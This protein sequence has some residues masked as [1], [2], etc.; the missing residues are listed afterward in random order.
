MNGRAIRTKFAIGRS[1]AAAFIN[2]VR[3][4][5]AA[6]Y[7]NAVRIV[8]ATALINAIRV[9]AV[10]AFL[11]AGAG[12]GSSAEKDPLTVDPRGAGLLGEAQRAYARGNFGS[13]MTLA[14]SAAIYIPDV[15]DVW[16]LRGQVLADLY[17]FDESDSSFK[18]VLEIDPHYRSARFNMGHNAFQ[19]STYHAK[20]AFRTALG[21]YEAEAASLRDA[22]GED[23]PMGTDRDALATVLLQIGTTYHR[24]HLPDSAR[25]AY[26]QALAIDSSLARGYAWLAGIE[27]SLGALDDALANARRALDLEPDNPEHALLVG[28][29]LNDLER[30]DEAVPFLTTA[31]RE[32]PT[33]RTAIHSLGTAMVATGQEDVGAVYLAK[34]DSMELLRARIEQAHMGI[35]HDP[36]DPIRWENYAYLLHQAGQNAEALKAV[37]VMRQ[38]GPPAEVAGQ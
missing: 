18:R 10:A 19:Q 3:V 15:P 11:V 8:V 17:R 35:F 25:L 1:M 2:A 14:D 30:Y 29:L 37:H 6:A 20:D 12:C 7:V 9:A 38:L 16:F 28:V 36:K 23:D 13:A 27:Q 22:I 24:L 26:R 32:L 21:H 31:A 5:A 34:G 4:S 33:N